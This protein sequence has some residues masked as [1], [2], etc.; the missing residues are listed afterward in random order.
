MEC[1]KLLAP[2]TPV[3]AHILLR[4]RWVV[5]QLD[6]LKK[7]LKQ[8]ILR[9]ALNS[10]PRNL[11]E[12]YDQILNGIDEEYIEDAFKILQ[13]LVHSTR[14]L[15]L[16]EVAEVVAVRL[17]DE[18]QFDPASRLGEPRD[19]LAICSTLV[20]TVT[21]TRPSEYDAH[22][23]EKGEV[24]LAHFSVKEYLLSARIRRGDTEYTIEK[25]CQGI[26]AQTCLT[27]L[28][29]LQEPTMLT[30]TYP[31]DFP[32]AEY[33]AN[34]WFTH[35]RAAKKEVDKVNSL[36]LRLC[37]SNGAYTNWIRLRDLDGYELG[38]HDLSNRDIDRFPKSTKFAPPLYYAALAG[39]VELS[40][41][42]LANGANV[43]ACGGQYTYALQAAC[44][45]GYQSVIMLL[46]EN[47]ADINARSGYYATALHVACGRGHEGVVRLLLEHGADVH[48]KDRNHNTALQLAHKEKFEAVVRV[49]HEMKPS[50]RQDHLAYRLREAACDG[51]LENVKNLL[52]EGADIH[53][54]GGRFDTALQAA[55]YNGHEA[56]VKLLLENGADVNLRGGQEF[57]SPLQ[58]ASVKGR[59]A[60]A[61]MLL[62]HGA[63]INAHGGEFDSALQGAACEGQEAMVK[64][65]LENGADINACVPG[66]LYRSPL[67]AAAFA[68]SESIVRLLLE[69]GIN[70]KYCSGAIL[71]VADASFVVPYGQYESAWCRIV[72]LMHEN[73]A[74]FTPE[75]FSSMCRQGGLAL[76]KLMLDIG[77]DFT[78][79]VD[80]YNTLLEEIVE[81]ERYALIQNS[82][83][84]VSKRG[85]KEIKDMIREKIASLYV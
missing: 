58:A 61:K 50:L 53:S 25:D 8:D 81:G 37:Q 16:A 71:S 31:D 85:Y 68:G 43:N 73:G 30:P 2:F 62:E 19:V 11:K 72:K 32:L 57:D 42:L 20:T 38:D 4:F 24:R 9:K 48:I 75:A 29:H 65:L 12:T 23:Y 77:L 27:Y 79:D 10:L 1:K 63:N 46:L 36:G 82:G 13:L 52:E 3:Y 17:D 80:Y 49:I 28:L 74:R 84:E 39:L 26:M 69:K 41:A 22:T 47:G 59:V 64:L 70:T 83:L 56:I 51:Q 60:I 45:V 40:R 66:C 33:A 34:Y 76:V 54:Q 15:D 44:V 18:P 7:Y 14:P 78:P 6:R 67:A 35:A 5:C 55:S 21:R